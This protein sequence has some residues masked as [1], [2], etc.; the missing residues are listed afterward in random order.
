MLIPAFANAVYLKV[1]TINYET[2]PGFWAG[3]KLSE[4]ILSTLKNYYLEVFISPLLAWPA[5]AIEVAGVFAKAL[6]LATPQPPP[7]IAA[8]ITT[9]IAFTK[10]LFWYN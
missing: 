6:T 7:T 8:K 10:E 9:K 4:V 2:S 5:G 1:E 3:G